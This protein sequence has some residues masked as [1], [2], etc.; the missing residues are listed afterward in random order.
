[1]SI[2][3]RCY[4][5]EILPIDVKLYPLK[6][7]NQPFELPVFA[8]HRDA[9]FARLYLYF[10]TEHTIHAKIFSQYIGLFLSLCFEI[11]Y[12][13]NV[14]KENMDNSVKRIAACTAEFWENVTR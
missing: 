13:Q 1:M 12:V 10:H 5:A 14:Q 2:D 8:F 7:I 6:L 11:W 4:M 3:T 9:C